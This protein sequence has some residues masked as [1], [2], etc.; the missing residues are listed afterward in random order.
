MIDDYFRFIKTIARKNP[1]MKKFRLVKEFS[2]VKKGYIRFVIEFRD[3]S[4][5]HV[6]EYV[7]SGLHK[8]NYS[9]HWQDKEKNLIIR[10]DNAPHHS[11]IETFPHH[12]HMKDGVKPSGE[13]TFA[14]ILEK[15]EQAI[16]V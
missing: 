12:L 15:I 7:N 14:E 11:N 16:A 3:N 4:E 9:Y 2:G 5:L 10:W 6:F 1:L 8:L 13:P